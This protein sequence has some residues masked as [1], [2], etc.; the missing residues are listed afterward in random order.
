MKEEEAI[1]AAKHLVQVC[2]LY[3]T[4]TTRIYVDSEPH[5]ALFLDMLLSA[6]M[7]A[8]AMMTSG[9]KLTVTLV[10]KNLHRRMIGHA[11]LVIA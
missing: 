3:N 6:V 11:C 7:G 9:F 5:E 1:T 4:D 8:A 2:V 10:S